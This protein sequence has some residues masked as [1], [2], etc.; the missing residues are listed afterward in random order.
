MALG[1]GGGDAAPH[2][3]PAGHDARCSPA[4][5][6]AWAARSR[7][8]RVLRESA[9]RRR[10]APIRSTFV[11]VTCFLVAVA[12]A[13]IYLPAR[14]AAPVGSDG[15]AEERLTM[16]SLLQNVRFAVRSLRKSPALTAVRGADAGALHRRHDRDLQR[17]LRG[18]VPA[19]AVRR[20]RRD[21]AR[22]RRPGRD[23]R[24][25]FSGGQLGRR[26]A[27][28][29][30]LSV[31]RPGPRR[32]LQPGR[33]GHA[34]ERGRRPGRRRLLR[35]CSGCSRPW[36]ADSCAEEDAPGRDNVVAAERR[37]L[38][39][40]VRGRSVGGRAARSGSTGRRTPVIGVMPRRD[41]LRAVR[42]GAVGAHGVH[43]RAAGR[44]TT[45]TSSPCSAGSSP[46]SAAR[47]PRPE[48]RG[49]RPLAG[50]RPIPTTTSDRGIVMAP[51]HGGAGRRL[52]PPALRAARRRRASCCSSP[53]P[54]SPTCCSPAARRA[55]ARWRFAPRSAR[56]AGTSCARR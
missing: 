2:G 53:A 6:S 3:D 4:W 43:S 48:M 26:E 19:A 36:A 31:L 7:A 44:C 47:R 37:A 56:A 1:A 41:G 52:P 9:L 55:R 28:R 45:S 16:E 13:A 39:P 21:P 54:T 42:R 30:K 50:E 40:A 32:E 5:R 33:R 35:A 15:R 17:G 49:H 25:S 29:P 24:S 14:R 46:A 22:V 51:L 38:A 8:G 12:L 20:T 27:R 10:R 23:M 34:G 11:A 18:A